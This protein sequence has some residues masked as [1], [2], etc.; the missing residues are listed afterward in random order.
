[1]GYHRVLHRLVPALLAFVALS[2]PAGLLAAPRA[3]QQAPDFKMAT[4][5]GQ[6][7]S[8]ERYRGQVLLLDFFAV[9]CKPC[10]ESIPHL[11]E[12][13][14]KYGKQGLQVLGV[15]ADEEG[16]KS[17][18]TFAEQN[19][20]AYPVALAGEAMLTDYGVRSV[21]ILFVIDRRGR[22]AEVFRGV[23]E[24]SGRSQE[25]LVRKLLAEKPAQ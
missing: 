15:S 17:V 11:N 2:A 22:V 3:G 19:R 16:E 18:R 12:L 4:L 14:Q 20:I 9:W 7:V 24:A 1:M 6:Q 10:R 8:L 23:T 5:T 25:Q 21:P 13:S